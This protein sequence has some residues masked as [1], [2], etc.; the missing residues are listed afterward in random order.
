VKV[1]AEL[2]VELDYVMLD[3]DG[4]K[5]ESSTDDG[6]MVYVH[7]EGDIPPKLE[8]ALEGAEPGAALEIT[9][10]P[11]E[12]FG[13]YDP[14]GIVSVPRAD[15]PPDHELAPG[16]WIEIHVQHEED[17]EHEHGGECEGHELA[18]Q[19]VEM[20]DDVVVLD[21]NHPLAGRRLTFQLKVRDVRTPTAA[22]LARL[23]EE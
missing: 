9:L 20:D 10:E 17:E 7:G 12:A 11:L 13:E 21:T 8:Q 4:Q 2:L 18:A 5:L 16:E 23:A 19:V 22:D 15:F 1:A 6:P 3:E 14:E